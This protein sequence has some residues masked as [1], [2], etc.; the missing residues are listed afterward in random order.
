MLEKVHRI[1]LVSVAFEYVIFRIVYPH[2]SHLFGFRRGYPFNYPARLERKVRISE[3]TYKSLYR[4]AN[5]L[6]AAVFCGIQTNY[7]HKKG[8]LRAEGG[9]LFKL[10]SLLPS[11]CVIEFE[12]EEYT[13]AHSEGEYFFRGSVEAMPQ[14]LH[15]FL[16][17]FL[18]LL[19]QRYKPYERKLGERLEELTLY[20]DLEEEAP[21]K[22][23][24]MRHK[25]RLE[26]LERQGKP[27]QPAAPK[28]LE[29]EV[30]PNLFEPRT[31]RR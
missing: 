26:E 16:H 15:R 12:H 31:L 23:R 13:F 19:M 11:V 18:P 2:K 6:L 9:Y 4:I 17:R 14:Q 24:Q 7:E 25:R 3:E 5:V 1:E 10:R 28:Q 27:A 22:V 29:R 8:S 20:P 21:R 30:M